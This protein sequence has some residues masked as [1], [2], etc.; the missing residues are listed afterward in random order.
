VSTT[1]PLDAGAA[2]E[3]LRAA[4]AVPA[5]AEGIDLIGEL[6][7]SG[8]VDPPSLVRRADGQTLQLTD[9]LYQVLESIDGSRDIE[10]I[11]ADVSARIDRQVSSDNITFLIEEKL[12]PLGVLKEPDGSEPAVQKLNPLLALRFRVSLSKPSVTRRITAPFA[13]L[14]HPVIV[15]VALA[16]FVAVLIWLFFIEGVAGST[17]TL[18]TEP[19]LLVLTFALTAVSAGWHEFGHAAACRYGGATPGTMGAGIYLVWPAFYTDVTDSYRLDRRGRLRTDLGG[20]YFN[21]LFALATVGVWA[22][23]G[24]EF[25]L[26]LVPLQLLQMVHQLLPFVRLDGYHILADLTGVPDLFARIKPTLQAALPNHEPDERVTALKPWV[27]RVVALWVVLVVPLLLLSLVMVVLAMPRMLATAWQTLG[28]ERAALATTWSDGDWWGVA[29]ALLSGLALLLPVASSFY[30][31]SR[32]AVRAT[33]G[34]WERAGGPVGRTLVVAGATGLAALAAF[35]WWPNGEYEPIHPNERGTILDGVRTVAAVPSGRPALTEERAE[36]L[37]VIDDAEADVI[38]ED[39]RPVSSTT[40]T[41]NEATEPAGVTPTTA[42]SRPTTT[43]T[44]STTTAPTSTTT[45]SP[46]TT[47]STTTEVTP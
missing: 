9:L 39:E 29:A 19:P 22:L 4:G 13:L 43:S 31:L 35:T 5:R 32:I 2:T 25:L 17:R 44:P 33:K 8:F 47:T 7:Q 3:Q 10:A 12:R 42:P 20:L 24:W 40:T 16:A 30:I 18:L 26:V 28:I 36:D 45:T 37:D 34:T 38:D 15:T 41:T 46:P 1:H 27:R 21:C 14:F 11:A 23:T 6:E